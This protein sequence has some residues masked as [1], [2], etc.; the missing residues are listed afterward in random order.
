MSAKGERERKRQTIPESV[1]EERCGASAQ[2]RGVG[3]LLR[4][5]AVDKQNA[6]FSFGAEG[7]A[8]GVCVIGTVQMR[9]NNLYMNRFTT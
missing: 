8:E 3:A 5:V 9:G 1:L 7:A 2:A 6:K 4:C